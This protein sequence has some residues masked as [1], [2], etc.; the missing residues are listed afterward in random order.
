MADQVMR[1]PDAAEIPVAA[2]GQED[3]EQL[4]RKEES[5]A[6]ETM[7]P[8]LM[9]QCAGCE[10]EEKLQ[11]RLMRKNDNAHSDSYA[12]GGVHAVAGNSDY[13]QPKA[14]APPVGHLIQR[15]GRAPPATDDSFMSALQSTKGGGLP[16]SGETRQFMEQRF[17]ADFSGVRIHTGTQASSLSHQIQAQAFTHGGDIYFN[18]GK[19]APQTN[20]GGHLLA[21]ELTHTLQ[22]GASTVLAPQAQQRAAT[23]TS[24]AIHLQRAASGRPVPAQL[25]NAVGK[26]KGEAGKVDA[27]KKGP[28]G[29]RLGWE[30]L[31]NYFKTTL[32]QDKVIGP[33]GSY[34]R[35]AVAE[36]DIR[37]K[38]NISG[39][40][41]PAHPAVERNG[42]YIRDAMPSWCGIFVYW[43]LHKAG[44]PMK[45]WLLGGKNIS[46]DAAY[47]PG[48]T[49]QAGDI[50]YRNNHSHFAIVDKTTGNT[51]TT[52]NGNTAG[53]DNLGG[54]IQ[55]RD[56]PLSDWTAFFDPLV[57][58]DGALSGGE[59]NPEN[60]RPLTLN[61]LRKKLFHVDA[62][63][64]E[65]RKGNGNEPHPTASSESLVQTKP[66]T[67]N[68][69]VNNAGR[70]QRNDAETTEEKHSEEE[71]Q[72]EATG[73]LQE[74]SLQ[75]KALPDVT[76]ALK[77]QVATSQ[78]TGFIATV[79]TATSGVAPVFRQKQQPS[80]EAVSA[81]GR[82][83]PGLIQR[84]IF[85]DIANAASGAASTV[86]GAVYDTASGAYDAASGAVSGA[87]DWAE[88][89]I[90]EAKAYMLTRIRNY[91]A[92]TRGYRLLTVILQRDPVTGA[93]VARNG[94]T[95]LDAG[96]GIIPVIGDGI[97]TLLHQTGTWNEAA[98]FVGGRVAAFSGMVSDI[99]ER[100][101]GFIN[102]LGVADI[103]HPSEV[104]ERLFHLIKG[105][106]QQIIQFV[107]QTAVVFVEMVK[108]VMIAQVAGFVQRHLPRLYPF[109]RVALGF[110]PITNERVPRNG[111]NILHALFEVTEA[112][113]EQRRQLLETG[114]FQKVASWIDAGIEVFTQLY[115]AIRGGFSLIWDTISVDSLLHPQAA[116]ERIYS[117][118]AA[119]VSNVLSWI[120]RTALYIIQVIKEALLTRLSAWA[121][122]QRGYFLITLLIGQDP[123]THRR[124]PF[125]VENV[126]RAFMSL[127]EGGEE[128]FAQMQASGAIGRAAKRIT[129]AVARLGFTVA[130]IT[131]LFAGLWQSLTLRD[132]ANPV[133]LF[134]RVLQTFSGPVRR[135]LFFVVEIVKIIVEVILQIMQFPTDLIGNIMA[136]AMAAWESIKRDPVGFL[137]NLLR[138]IR[139]GFVQFFDRILS[140]LTFGLTNW[141]M[142]ELRDAGVP[143]LTDFS[144]RGLITWVL[145]VLQISMEAIWQKLAAHPRIGPERVARIRGMMGR[146]EGIWTF[147]KDVQERGMAAIWDKIQEQLSNLW[148]T[149]LG[150]VRNWV[151]EQI[152][153]RVVTR[154]LSML[155]PTGI[156]AVINSAIAI[157]R[158]IQSFVR[159]VQQ[160]LQIVNSFVMG[161]AD[162]AAGNVRTAA[163]YVEGAMRQGMPVVIGFLANQV[164]LSGIG[165]RVGQLIGVARQKVD[166]ALTWLVHKAVDTGFA[167]FERLLA[168][169]KSSV[170]SGGSPQERLNHGLK[171]AQTVVNKFAGRR[172]GALIL[173][174]LLATIKFRYGMR[175][176]DVLPRGH[177]WA[178]YAQI[179]PEGELTTEAQVDTG[180]SSEETLLAT[181]EPKVTPSFPTDSLGRA[182]GSFGHVQGVKDEEG[183]ESMAAVLQTGYLPGDHRGHLIGDRFY[184]PSDAGNLVPMHRILNLSTFKTYENTLAVNYNKYK[185]KNKAVML[186]MHIVPAYP[187]NDATNPTHFRPVSVVADSRI[188]TL[189]DGT[190]PQEK[191]IES[192]KPGPFENPEP[193]V[194]ALNINIATEANLM[195]LFGTELGK[196]IFRIRTTKFTGFDDL[197]LRVVYA[198]P[199]TQIERHNENIRAK[200]QFIK[201][202]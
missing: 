18:S 182:V 181:L 75:R 17:N 183:R 24:G 118:F 100:I 2:A 172:V 85:D 1:M 52:V 166:Q 92:G 159:Y 144:P 101:V 11:P 55:T 132:L 26:A 189:K 142:A 68:W 98:G 70:L 65:G 66:A 169:G 125:T 32:G 15:N 126:V 137:M 199:E 38:R 37:Q 27:N 35:G 143:A 49:P 64:E 141:L 202:R 155:D 115:L 23:A 138:A 48:H 188:V 128:Q 139:Q 109:L 147:I 9:R 41:P 44:V 195:D 178:V 176:L 193:V 127:M 117:H 88:D 42:P 13:L 30:R 5:E 22:Q 196:I 102:S 10:Q 154:L 140:H 105:I 73:G 123:F 116:F 96:L 8:V 63:M 19:Y 148:E 58:K 91:V 78:P 46:P 186:Y 161:V 33:G 107:E 190:Q 79:A 99:G 86:G 164:G 179:N 16:M 191:N 54:Q 119:P 28:D 76:V 185:K 53:E 57:L 56:H 21:H 40:L 95:L 3:D 108:R 97:R 59:T 82:G 29:Q 20:A 47:P 157:Y 120:G 134:R 61:E 71:Q 90:N 60:I 50:A 130:Y 36:Q 175:K 133:A 77:Q 174:P 111:A 129:S 104:L 160:L 197:Q 43:A 184:G 194:A 4:Q 201:F 192:Y 74:L 110:D 106:L 198:I 51:V 83:P 168:M 146:L 93:A 180:A 124:V 72:K 131:G 80:L 84:D 94:D 173:K 170:I 62:K 162:I 149:I 187:G 165:H 145:A 152:V 163:N 7:Q 81:T 67:G 69:S 177:T 112:G 153:N 113:A 114:T 14:H 12:A 156:M 45:P 158:A 25:T 200:A 121:K 151:M 89:Q 122:E 6:N 103:R 34:V 135:L 31:L 39:A 136:R 150:A 167:I 87:M 171:D